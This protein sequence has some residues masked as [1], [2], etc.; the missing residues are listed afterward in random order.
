[1]NEVHTVSIT[2]Q[3]D[4][5]LVY[6]YLSKPENFPLWSAFIKAMVPAGDEW[7]ATT[8]ESTVRI[9]FAPE[10]ELGVVDHWVKLPAGAEVY[11][12]LRV[13]ANGA[14]SEVLFTVFR[15]AEMTD[16]QFEADIALVNTD[17][18]RLKAVL[19]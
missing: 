15:L 8:A 13:V 11:V 4:A 10:N 3:R 9:R 18:N 17:M 19:E 14:D 5:N 12:P 6:R 2:I 7:L 16:Q 1:M